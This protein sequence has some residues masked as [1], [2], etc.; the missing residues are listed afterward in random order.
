VS[1]DWSQNI[2]I[3]Q[4]LK[5]RTIDGIVSGHLKEGDLLPS[6]RQVAIELQINPLTASKAYQMLVDEGLVVSER[7][8]GMRIKAGAQ[9]QLLDRERARFINE[10]WPQIIERMRQLGIDLDELAQPYNQK[11]SNE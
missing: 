2:P 5:D 8:V 3:Y 1:N 7:G 10:Q 4:Q 9:Q 11:A 6:V